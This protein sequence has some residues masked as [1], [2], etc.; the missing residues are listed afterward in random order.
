MADVN[1]LDVFA[2]SL[3]AVESPASASASAIRLPAST[4]SRVSVSRSV[5]IPSL[6]SVATPLSEVAALSMFAECFPTV[7]TRSVCDSL[8]SSSCRS[9]A[10]AASAW[11][12]DAV[13][14][15]AADSDN[16]VT[17]VAISVAA[18]R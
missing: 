8:M 9:I 14:I 1:V 10:F 15:T 7:V 6:S 16:P 3:A 4:T 18:A 5:R 13:A 2:S 17:L 12:V 11:E